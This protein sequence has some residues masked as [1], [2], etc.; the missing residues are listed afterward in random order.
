MRRADRATIFV[1]TNGGET[2]SLHSVIQS[3]QI[4]CDCTLRFGSSS[5]VLYVS[6]LRNEKDGYKKR[7]LMICQSAE[8]A[9]TRLMGEIFNHRNLIDQP[10]IAAMTVAGK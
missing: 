2:W 8:Y 9:T 4:T 10:Y 1:S 5:D 7:E 3:P 6:A